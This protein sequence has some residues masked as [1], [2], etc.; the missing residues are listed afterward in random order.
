MPLILRLIISPDDAV[1]FNKLVRL[2]EIVHR[3]LN[4][5]SVNITFYTDR[6]FYCD[7]INIFSIDYLDRLFGLFPYI[8]Q[9]SSI[10]I[11][12]VAIYKI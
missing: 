9:Y 4:L 11:K 3:S 10:Y 7:F 1:S 5:Y 2:P 6:C 8:S 12:Y